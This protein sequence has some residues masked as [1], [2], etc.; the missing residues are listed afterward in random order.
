MR[1]Y[2]RSRAGQ[3]FFFTV[4]THD[5][6]KILTTD[7]AT[8]TLRAAIRAVR[9]DHPFR[10]TAIV[11][12]P[13]HIH[14]VWELPP[15]DTDYSARWRLIKAAFTRHWLEA[16]GEEGAV[17]ASRKRRE[18]RAVWQRRFYEHTCR[19][20]EDLKR[21]VDYIHVN[22]L[23]HRLVDRVAEWPWSSF[24]HYVRLGEYPND[25]GRSDAWYGDEFRD[26][27]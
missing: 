16:G 20:D 8:A 11:L 25:W 22:P 15:G 10:I 27:E 23:K 18:E 21:C 26:A 4:V 14:A 19:D 7:L 9:T 5:R 13:D 2:L 6:R 12:L 17:G 24:H 3:V 1:R